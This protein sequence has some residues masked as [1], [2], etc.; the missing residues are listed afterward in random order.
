MSNYVYYNKNILQQI[1]E[2]KYNFSINYL[3]GH[4]LKYSIFNDNL[5]YFDKSHNLKQLKEFAYCA[6][7]VAREKVFKL[8]KKYPEYFSSLAKSTI[9]VQKDN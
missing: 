7:I 1:T 8:Y 9:N 3:R 5:K 2:G 6:G 4:Y